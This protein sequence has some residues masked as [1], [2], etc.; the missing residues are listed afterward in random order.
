MWD[1]SS[2]R[3]GFSSFPMLLLIETSEKVLLKDYKKPLKGA[4]SVP[5]GFA[6]ALSNEE[7]TFSFQ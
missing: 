3:G 4:C 6:L 7:Q 2:K 1:V 5:T